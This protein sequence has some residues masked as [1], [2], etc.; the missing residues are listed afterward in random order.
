MLKFWQNYSQKLHDLHFNYKAKS[1]SSA[2]G[3]Y[4]AN[5]ELLKDFKAKCEER[6]VTMTDVII[7]AILTFLNE[8]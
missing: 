3:K 5:K 8:K 1:K 2:T 6:G 4:R 7:K